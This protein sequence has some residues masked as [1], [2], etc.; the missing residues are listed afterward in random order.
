MTDKVD[1]AVAKFM[2]GYNCAQAV[3]FAH[4]D[5]LGLE[6]NAALKMACGFGAGMG[7][8]EE[9][10]EPSLGGSGGFGRVGLIGMLLQP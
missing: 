1:V 4:C 7:R 6:K 10:F 3:L 8:K 2:S 5:E 9:V